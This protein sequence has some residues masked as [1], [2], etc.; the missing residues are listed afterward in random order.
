MIKYSSN[1]EVEWAQGIGETDEDKIT[2]VAECSDG[3]YIAGGYFKSS[4]I[5][6]ENGISLTNKGFEDGMVIKYSS[7]GKVEWAQ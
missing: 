5:D 2:S 3:G 7:N 6:L 4:S 1:G